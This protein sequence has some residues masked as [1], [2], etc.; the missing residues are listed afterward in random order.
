MIK[1]DGAKVDVSGGESLGHGTQAMPQHVG[2]THL[3]GCQ[4]VRYAL[5]GSHLSG[6]LIP[7]V[8]REP[9]TRIL[10]VWIGMSIHQYADRRKTT[11][12]RLRLS[13]LG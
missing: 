2:V 6:H 12:G 3:T 13:A 11:R 4:R 9:I 7:A 8:H 10:P 1:R 5:R